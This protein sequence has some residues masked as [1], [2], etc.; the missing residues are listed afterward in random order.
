MAAAGINKML[1]KLCVSLCL[2]HIF[3]WCE[4]SSVTLG[5]VHSLWLSDRRVVRNVFGSLLT[6]HLGLVKPT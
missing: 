4:T 2:V 6:V 1:R 5:E 3:T